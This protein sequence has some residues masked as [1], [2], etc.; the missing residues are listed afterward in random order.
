M[1]IYEIEQQMLITFFSFSLLFTSPS[2]YTIY[3]K[4]NYKMPLKILVVKINNFNQ[5][6]KKKENKK[7]FFSSILTQKF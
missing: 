4:K 2:Q 7:S 6:F 5:I 3:D 1:H